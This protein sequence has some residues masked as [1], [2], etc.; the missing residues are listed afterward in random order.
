[1]YRDL[2]SCAVHVERQWS[3]LDTIPGVQHWLGT[4][5]GVSNLAGDPLSSDLTHMALAL[6]KQLEGSRSPPKRGKDEVSRGPRM[7]EYGC[8]CKG[9]GK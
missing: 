5:G 7:I 4:T 2:L 9:M 3:T 6:S 8:L 1:M